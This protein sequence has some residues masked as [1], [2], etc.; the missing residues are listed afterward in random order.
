MLRKNVAIVGAKYGVWPNNLV[1]EV[2]IS[3]ISC[4]KASVAPRLNQ[5]E[6]HIMR[7]SPAA[8]IW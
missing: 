7:R 4:K 3:A 5:P 6:K 2:V 1:I 8:A